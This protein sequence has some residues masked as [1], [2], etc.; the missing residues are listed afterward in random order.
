MKYGRIHLVFGQA[1]T[2]WHGLTNPLS[3]CPGQVK[4]FAGRV[5]CLLAWLEKRISYIG[6]GNEF[7]HFPAKILHRASRLNFD[8]SGPA[9]MA[10]AK[11]FKANDV[12][13]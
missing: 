12:V 9:V 6:K 11:L 4:F 13:S 5:K 8:L 2:E 10:R 3:D 1:Q 7:Q